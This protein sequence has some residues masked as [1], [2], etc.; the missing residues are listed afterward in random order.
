MGLKVL[1]HGAL[2]WLGAMSLSAGTPLSFLY[3]QTPRYQPAAVERFP[4]GATIQ[5][6]VDGKSRPLVP[7]FAA[8]AD[9]TVSFDGRRVL[10]A[11]KQKAADPWQI[12]EVALAGGQPRRIAN[13]REDAITP[14]YATVDR[15]VYARR[16]PAGYQVETVIVGG[17]N[18][19]RIT[20]SPGDHLVTDVL[21]DGR[22]LFEAPHP[23]TAGR[24]VYSVYVDG[25]GVE[26]IR[27]DHAG[28]R[29]AGVQTA[30]GDIVFESGGRLARFTS[31][32]AVQIDLP[33]TPGEFA[34]RIAELTPGDLLAAFRPSATQAFALF[35][36]HPGQGAPL[37]MWAASGVQ[38]VQP[39]VVR[40]HE[41]PKRFPS[42]VGNREGANLL[43]LNAYTSRSRIAAGSVAAVRVWAL[44]DAGMAVAIGKAPVESDGSFFV[45][46]PSE[47]AI[48]FELLDRA[49]KAVAAEKGWFWARRGEQRICVGCHAGPERAPENAAP[50][51]LLR[52]TEP[53][54]MALPVVT[55]KRGPQ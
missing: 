35:D 37:R 19:D 33:A 52:T 1:K 21:R 48:R 36:W 22:I 16:T 13:F 28:D 6:V 2:I 50:A 11:G 14:F 38:A 30:D 31:A 49:G 4:E 46:S 26:T 27:C 41:I 53:V 20:Y 51:V 47:H 23:G 8:S 42:S 54:H 7:A 43:C 39:V 25:T 15:V 9:A 44:D 32:R 18:I 10:F 55:A 3:T 45:Q 29:H 34:G 17:G 24:D 12:W 5:S 40:P